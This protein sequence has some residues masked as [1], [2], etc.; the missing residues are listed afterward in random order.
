VNKEFIHAKNEHS[1]ATTKKD[2]VINQVYLI[3]I[4]KM[5]NILVNF[6]VYFFMLCDNKPTIDYETMNKLMHILDIKKI[7]KINS[8]NTIG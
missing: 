5:N 2:I 1:Y 7:P 4:G 6:F 3:I 8:S